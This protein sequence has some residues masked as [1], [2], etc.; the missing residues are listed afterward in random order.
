MKKLLFV[1]TGL[2]SYV[3]WTR[4]RC[5]VTGHQDALVLHEDGRV[6]LVCGHCGYRSAGWDLRTGQK[7]TTR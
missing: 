5:A 4:I 6:R 1:L 2:L 7:E 3:L